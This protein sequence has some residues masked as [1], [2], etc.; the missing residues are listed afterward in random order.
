MVFSFSIFQAVVQ[1]KGS[2]QARH[3]VVVFFWWSN[4]GYDPIE[5]VGISAIQQRFEPLDLRGVEACEI[6]LREP[7]EYEVTLLRSPMPAPEQQPPAS[8][9][10][11]LPLRR[12]E[13]CRHS[14]RLN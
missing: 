6:S 5:Q 8:D 3:V 9:F 2:Q 11:M 7:A 4:A 14:L 13:M 10:S 1:S 12:G